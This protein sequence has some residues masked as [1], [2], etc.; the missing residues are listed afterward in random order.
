MWL[1]YWKEPITVAGLVDRI[2][3]DDLGEYE[4]PRGCWITDDTE[5]CWRS[6]CVAEG[7]AMETLTH[8]HEVVL[9]ESEILI[10]RSAHELDDFTRQY[11][12][13]STWG[14]PG[15][16][17]KYRRLCIDWREVA[18]QHSGIIITPY[19]WSRRL[20][21]PYSWYYTWDCAS[22]CIWKAGA[23]KDIRLIEIDH[24]VTRIGEKEEAA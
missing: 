6:W 21:A 1:K 4:K 16:P 15:Q 14:P 13:R 2:Q 7:F 5:H 12:V 23:I 17:N 18:K 8:K 24:A 22:G 20:D 9:D 10:L 19:Q 11:G 3:D